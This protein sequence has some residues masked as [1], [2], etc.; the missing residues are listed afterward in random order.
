RLPAAAQ[1][2]CASLLLARSRDRTHRVTDIGLRTS[3]VGLGCGLVR[4]ATS[5]AS[6]GKPSASAVWTSAIARPMSS[7]A[8]NRPVALSR[9]WSTFSSW[10]PSAPADALIDQPALGLE[11]TPLV[12]TLGL[13][14]LCA[15]H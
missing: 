8:G 4:H 15:D 9:Y 1:P 7:A 13:I 2:A 5:A 12:R 6:S 11:V 14:A 3:D 10:M